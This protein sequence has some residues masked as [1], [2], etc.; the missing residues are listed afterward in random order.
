MPLLVFSQ[1]RTYETFADGTASKFKVWRPVPAMLTFFCAYGP[2]HVA[3][4]YAVAQLHLQVACLAITS[5]MLHQLVQH[6]LESVKSN[7]RLFANVSQ[8]YNI[9]FVYPRVFPSRRSIGTQT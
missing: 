1:Y 8:E 9:R 6:H 4:I 2:A 7:Q 3:I 5:I